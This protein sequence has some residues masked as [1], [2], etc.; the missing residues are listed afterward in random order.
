MTDNRFF[1]FL[2]LIYEPVPILP[3]TI[4]HT[5]IFATTPAPETLFWIQPMLAAATVLM[6]ASLVIL[7]STAFHAIQTTLGC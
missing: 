1:W 6:I 3:P 2:L 4:T 5:L 7:P